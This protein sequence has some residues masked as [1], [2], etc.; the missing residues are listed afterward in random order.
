MINVSNEWRAIV[1]DATQDET[2]PDFTAKATIL[3]ANG[4]TLPITET[5]IVVGGLSII[6]SVSAS[7]L[8]QIGT[9][10]INE[11]DILLNNIEHKFDDVDFTDAVVIPYVGLNKST[12]T[13]WLK[14]GTFTVDE[15][16]VSASIIS[17]ISLDHMN[18]LDVPFSGVAISFPTTPLVLAQA[19]C[20]HC[21]VVLFNSTFLN[22]AVTITRKPTDEALTCRSIIGWI[23]QMGGNF[24]RCNVDGA[25]E[26]KWYDVATMDKLNIIN[27]GTFT[28]PA[29]DT[30]SAGTFTA[31]SKDIIS[32]GA[33]TDLK[34]YHHL[35]SFGSQPTIGTDDIVVTGVRVKAMGIDSDYGETF[36]YGSEGYIIEI[37]DNPLIQEG[38]AETIANTVGKKIAG[39]RFRTA[40]VQVIT[41]PSREAGDI[42]ILSHKNNTYPIIF[43]NYHYQFGS[44]DTVASDAE[45]P[46]KKKSSYDP[47]SKIAVEAR[48]VAKQEVNFYDLAKQQFSNLIANAM[49]VFRTVIPMDNGGEIEYIHDQPKMAESKWRQYVTSGGMI[50]QNQVNGVWTITS[51]EDTEGNALFNVITARGINAE[52][53]KVLTSFTVGENFSVDSLG[54]TI[55][56]YLKATNADISGN[57]N[58]ISGGIGPFS[59]SDRGL[60]VYGAPGQDYIC[61]FSKQPDGTMFIYTS[62]DLWAEGG[63]MI[64]KRA[65]MNDDLYVAGDISAHTYSDHTPFYDGDA[66]NEIVKISD[67]GNGEIDHSSLPECAKKKITRKNEEYEKLINDKREVKIV[68]VKASLK[69]AKIKDIKFIK[70]PP[71]IEEDGRSLGDMISVLTKGIQQLIAKNEEQDR[72]IIRQGELILELQGK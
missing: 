29:M 30:I 26:L 2:V 13:E 18:K 53:I 15:A 14:K 24:A 64:R 57:I 68:K 16:T 36:L 48:K 3:L 72:L 17:L 70:I 56:N 28:N 55:L 39:M 66:L 62:G 40:A 43:S 35:Y 21:G 5:D 69:S 32:A 50:Q 31:P 63:L 9:A 49:G 38:M 42:G 6:D 1:A 4:T 54:N 65:V 51:A 67:D 45:T 44:N 52:W 25:V 41:D 37:V 33:F 34:N 58:A 27:A 61:Q 20:L 12:A 10:F 46:S 7:N 8:F 71:I 11:N 59:I 47:T 22:S 19:V 60:L 23:A